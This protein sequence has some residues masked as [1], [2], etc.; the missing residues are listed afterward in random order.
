[1]TPSSP[2]TA[3]PFLRRLRLE[4][5]SQ[6]NLLFCISQE[7]GSQTGVR[8]EPLHAVKAMRKSARREQEPCYFSYC[9]HPDQ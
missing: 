1:M 9:R 7:D 3:S 5:F 2:F 4:F 6:R 8:V